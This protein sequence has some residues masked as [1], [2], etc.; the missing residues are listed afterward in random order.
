MPANI[1]GRARPQARKGRKPAGFVTMQTL[2]T[3]CRRQRTAADMKIT[4]PPL[5]VQ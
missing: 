4:R 3:I 1:V 5:F 2:G